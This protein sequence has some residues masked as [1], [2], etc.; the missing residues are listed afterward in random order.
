MEDSLVNVKFVVLEVLE[1]CVIRLVN[2]DCVGILINIVFVVFFILSVKKKVFF[3]VG[4]CCVG[5]FVS[6]LGL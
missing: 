2:I 3:V 6:I 5:I 1:R 4:V